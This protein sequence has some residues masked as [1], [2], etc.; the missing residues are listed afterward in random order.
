MIIPNSMIVCLTEKFLQATTILIDEDNIRKK[1]S[2]NGIF[3]N[4]LTLLDV[5]AANVDALLNLNQVTF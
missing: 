2:E 4:L 3:D 5:D 1:T